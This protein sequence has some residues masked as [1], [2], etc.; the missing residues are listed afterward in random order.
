MLFSVVIPTYN[1]LSELQRCLGALE[2]V[3]DPD[4]EV[5]VCVDGSTD[6][7]FEW[8]AEAALDLQLKVLHHPDRAN[9]GRSATRNLSLPHIRGKYTLFLDSDM[10]VPPEIF[11]FHLAE[12]NAGGTVSIG[13]VHYRNS[14]SNLWVRYTS[15]RGVA[16]Y[17]PGSEVPFHYF[18]TPNTALPTEWWRDLGGFDEHIN[19]YG[20]ED[21]ELGY[22]IFREYQPRYVFNAAAK[23]MTVQPKTLRE[24]LPQL[25]EYGATGLPYIVRKW[26]ELKE[27]YWVNRIDSGRLKDRLF[28]GLAHPRWR[29][30]VWAMLRISPFALQKQLIN[31]L[32]IS[33]VHEGYRSVV[34]G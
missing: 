6:G 5:L 13:P 10:E 12:L 14:A 20:G 8:L 31:Y 34:N 17:P 1:N 15:E 25:K 9:R 22:R 28:C 2:Q 30:W 7:T 26:P 16:K 33:H 27:V 4:F 11:Q 32:V 24:A 21:M 3:V 18:I 29:G 19:R 23:V